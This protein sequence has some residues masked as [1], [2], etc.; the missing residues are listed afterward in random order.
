[1]EAARQELA[2]LEAPSQGGRLVRIRE[3]KDVVSAPA[4]QSLVVLLGAVGIVLLVACANVANLLLARTASRSR[5]I[6]IR[7]ALGCGALSPGAAIPDREPPAWLL[8]RRG[9][10]GDQRVG[11]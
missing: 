2:A 3:L 1:M 4:R 5:E 9:R 11:E 10:A 7:A 8:R 6:A